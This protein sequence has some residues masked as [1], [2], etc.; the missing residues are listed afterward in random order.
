MESK[1][2]KP[3]PKWVTKMRILA[4]ELRVAVMLRDLDDTE[5]LVNQ[6]VEVISEERKGT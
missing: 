3:L 6:M 5:K 2:K 1:A 4:S